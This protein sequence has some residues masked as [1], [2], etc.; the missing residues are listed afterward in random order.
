M[1]PIAAVSVLALAVSIERV[2]LVLFRYDING[3]TFMTQIQKLV[4]ANNVDRAIKLCNAAPNAA[5]SR[6]V[7][8]GLVRA[9]KGEVEI[10]NAIEEVIL[11]VVP[12]LQKRTP[13]LVMLANLATLLGLLG[14]IMGL[15]RAFG[16]VAD[17][18]PEQRAAQIT[19]A[20]AVAMNTTAFGLL[21][22]VPTLFVYLVL[23]GISRKIVADIDL[24]SIRLENL[25]V[26]RGKGGAEPA[27]KSE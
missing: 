26:A 6:V 14:T 5:L 24:Y 8:A 13:S 3:Q 11:E 15:T 4:L 9:N 7:K 10:R 27:E 17:A 12:L 2:V 19:G 21:V 1:Y 22:A 20:I 16:V 18:L 23:S 25:L